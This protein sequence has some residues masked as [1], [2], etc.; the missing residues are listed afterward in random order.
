M[1]AGDN[2]TVAVKTDGTLWAWGLGS[3]GRLGNGNIISI[4]SPVQIGSLTNWKQVSS[5]QSETAALKTDGTL[6]TWGNNNSG[7]L[8]DGTILSK[9]SPIQVGALT[10]WKQVSI[11]G[12]DCIAILDGYI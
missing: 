3:F 7:Q 2:H 9:S 6:W 12:A 1:S 4:S 11:F 8:G 5:G 10:N